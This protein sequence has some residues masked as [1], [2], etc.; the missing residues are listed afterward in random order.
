LFVGGWYDSHLPGTLAAFRHYAAKG[1]P[2]RLVVGPWPHMP[3]GRRLAGIDFGPEA[4]GLIDSLQLRWFDHWLKGRD[5]GLLAEPAVRLFEMG[6]NEWRNFPAWPPHAAEFHLA[7]DGL[8]S[9]DERAGRLVRE[10]PHGEAI[11]YLVHDPWR[12]AP[13]VGGAFGMPPGP[14]DR[15]AVDAR[16]D[17]LTFTTEPFTREARLVGD[18]A[19]RLWLVADAPSV[20]VSC[21]L[22]R[23]T[24]SGSALTLT[25]G[26]RHLP[27][28]AADEPVS[29]AMRA[30]CA[31]L[32]PGEA[33]R[34]SLAAASFPA[35]P[36]N[37]GT[38]RPPTD[39][40]LEEARIVTLGVR[41][42][43]STASAVTLP[44]VPA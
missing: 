8:A 34:L 18:V 19:A 11:D 42:G 5:T 39:A 28:G 16:G 33:L 32:A 41:H 36:V 35:Y 3:W 7:G 25:Q 13:A 17:V 44:L 21:T 10:R 12:P 38:G 31:S 1:V 37:P 29:V 23:V 14:V 26:Y 6:R 30:I 24:R 40:S 15:C 2:A 20:D 22:S 43:G 9:T 27:T 4:A